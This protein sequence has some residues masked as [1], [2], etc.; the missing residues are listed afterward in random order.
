MLRTLA[1]Q[2][3]L[4]RRKTVI[5]TY[6]SLLVS[7]SVLIS[8]EHLRS[9]AKESFNRSIAGTDLIVGAPTGELNLLLYSVFRMGSPTNNIQYTSFQ[10]LSQHKSVTWAIPLSLGDSHRGYRVLGTNNA[11][12]EHFSYGDKRNLSFDKGN[13]LADLFD[14]VIG[15]EVASELGYEIG[16]KVV[17]SHGT[18]STSFHNHDH[19]PFSI[20]GI[21][22]PTGTSVDK[23]V[24]V[25]L[26]AIEA[27]HLPP[28]QLSRILEQGA[29]DILKPTSITSVL[30]GLDNKFATFAL[31]RQIN[32]FKD[33]RL[34]AVLPGVAMTQLWQLMENV[35]SLLR[36]ISLLVL[37]ASLFGLTT[38]LLASMNERR[39]EIAVLRMIGAS[40]RVLFQLIV[41]EAVLITVFA[42]ASALL[43]V[44][45]SLFV[46]SD[47]LIA[48]YGLFLSSNIFTVE[49]L[50]LFIFIL[51][52]VILAAFMPAIEAY[53]NGLNSKLSA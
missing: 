14:V 28:S 1:F 25:S 15:A 12:F 16:D 43:L 38:M 53:R 8:V 45:A 24:H 35:E 11:Y 32:N 31:Q 20:A 46:L 9:E 26:E 17:I 44:W 30:I 23:S 7:I 6:L 51:F 52:T 19:A 37:L 13:K 5:L 22:A 49:I 48:Q 40:P 41:L 33:D 29:S 4:S 3:L 42:F 50:V 34:M 36:I 21:L 47:W 2:S 18:G 39:G 27:I 10:T